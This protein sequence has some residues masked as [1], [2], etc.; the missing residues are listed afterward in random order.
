MNFLLVGFYGEDNLGDNAILEAIK[1][2][3]PNANDYCAT[4]GKYLKN[5]NTIK[6]RGILSWA[7][8]IKAATK[9]DHSI[10]SGGILQDW[11]SEGVLFFALRIIAS[12]ILNCKPSLWGA[13]I[14]P[15][16]SKPLTSITK[17]AL[18][19]VDC[20]WLRDTT[21]LKLYE[22]L[23]NKG[24]NLGADW[25]WAYELPNHDAARIKNKELI[26]LRPWKFNLKELNNLKLEKTKNN[27]ITGIAARNEDIKEIRSLFPDSEIIKPSD[28]E[29]L[30][31]ICSKYE[32]GTAMRYHV[33]LAMIRS[34]VKTTLI[35]YDSKV[36]EL[37][38]A[39]EAPS[40]FIQKSEKNY[41]EMQEAFKNY[42]N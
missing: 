11:T 23:T 22:S 6:R 31:S 26:N 35:P 5:K 1:K 38:S 36:E 10:F 13:G 27:I 14:G 9:C 4:A 40:I 37:K 7:P 18:K 32:K 30:L 25:S 12:S 28:F 42:S 21:S 8:F 20:A 41:A 15:L 33:A 19:H 2:N 24:G 17:K 16:R 39:L 3:I 29:Q 34:G